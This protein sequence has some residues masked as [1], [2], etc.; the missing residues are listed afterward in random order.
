M[1]AF[2]DK[3]LRKRFLSSEE[4]WHD[5]ERQPSMDE[6]Y[7]QALN[8]KDGY[9]ERN[10]RKRATPILKAKELNPLKRSYLLPILFF[11]F[12]ACRE[13]PASYYLRAQ[14]DSTRAHICKCPPPDPKPGGKFP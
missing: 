3:E 4:L 1:K 7:H 13:W 8:R 11:F 2:K 9:F 6:A 12:V 5:P 14:E 10:F